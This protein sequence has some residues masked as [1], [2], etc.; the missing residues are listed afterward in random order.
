MTKKQLFFA[1]YAKGFPLDEELDAIVTFLDAYGPIESV[2]RRT[3]VDKITKKHVFKGSCFIIFKDVE[4]CKKFVEADSIKFKDTELIRKFKNDYFEQKKKEIQDKRKKGKKQDDE[5]AVANIVE[6]SS[7]AKGAVLH[8]S[9]LNKNQSIT[10][11]EIKEQ[12]KKIDSAEIAYIDFNKGETEG[13]IRF[14]EENKASEVFQK[15]NDGVLEV[16]ETKITFKVVKG[17]DEED[18]LKKTVEA[19][20]KR[21]VNAKKVGGKKRKGNFGQKNKSKRAK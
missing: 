7:F 10:R 8:F 9:G 16:S 21:R 11:E 13:Y 15:L 1:A 6:K 4:T 12:L 14:A 18:Y 5:S 2:A 3:N 19:V 20:N 17:Q